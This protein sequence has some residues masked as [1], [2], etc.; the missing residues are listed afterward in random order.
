MLLTSHYL[1]N[2]KQ[3]HGHGSQGP[4]DPVLMCSIISYCLFLQ[5]NLHL[6]L[7]H[8]KLLAFHN[9]R[10]SHILSPLLR[11]WLVHLHISVAP[12]W[13][14]SWHYPPHPGGDV[15]FDASTVPGKS[16]SW[17]FVTFYWTV[18]FHHLPP[19]LNYVPVNLLEGGDSVLLTPISLALC[20]A[21][22]I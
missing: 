15:R 20:M 4:R 18:R 9:S 8:I 16:L 10:P 6:T 2:E 1:R 21:S 11:C 5:T 12:P 22:R 7:S 3:I 14:L 17:N 19:S 13:Y